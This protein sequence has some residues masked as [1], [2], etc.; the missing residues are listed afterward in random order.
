[1]WY[2]SAHHTSRGVSFI[3]VLV[4]AAIVSLVFGGLF[5][6]IQV[7]LKL[8][9]DSKAESGALALANQRLEYIRSLS[10]DDIGTIGGI[11]DGLIP[12][13]STT[14]LNG[15]QY[16]ERVVVQFV[17]ASEDGT[18]A[19]DVNG[20]LAD[21]KLVKVEYSWESRGEPESISL[22][23]NIVPRGIETTAGGGTITVN[24]FDATVQPVSG[25]SV[26]IYNDTT[27]STIDTIRYTNIDGI[28]LFSGAPAA[29]NYEITVTNPGWSTDQTYSATTSNPNPV[30]PHVAV[31]ESEVS[32]MNFQID[33]LSNLTVQTIGPATTGDFTDLFDDTSLLATTS[34]AVVTGGSLLLSGGAG[35]YAATGTARS[36][37]STPV[38]ITSWNT[39]T[40]TAS[41]SA[42][43]TARIQVYEVTGTS[44]YTLIPDGDLPGNA[45]G[46]TGSPVDISSLDTGTYNALALGTILTTADTNVTPELLDWSITHIVAEPPI[47]NIDFTLT[48]NKTIGTT[49]SATPVY[50]YQQAHSTDGSGELDILDLE[51]DVYDLVLSGGV[52][53]IAEACEPIPY[54]LSPGVDET[55][56]LTLVPSSARSLRVRVQDGNGNPIVGADVDLTRSGYSDSDQ[57]SVCGQVFFNDALA[58]EIDYQ[59]DI[60]AAGYTDE[61]V[62]D[63][64]I[65][66]DET[67]T[68]VLTP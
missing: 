10:Y 55:L 66:N 45:T 62:T 54:S 35:S 59:V 61:T 24:V 37:S 53:D 50:K 56:K 7:M 2:I 1:M 20:I 57:T 65:Q 34:N 63:I 33:E 11:P 19:S 43:T 44:T 40:F 14:T 28:T 15:V 31:L 5:G 46:F 64:S 49:A 22:I 47:G 30:T 13:N 3:E 36:A 68:V 17:D 42:S 39:V 21:Y 41:S 6:S 58:A 32:T 26:H 23:S 60:S 9:S 29:A 25:A 52:Y 27:T 16:H 48:S 8:I 67:L 18:G 51:W 38:S 4:A 12:Q